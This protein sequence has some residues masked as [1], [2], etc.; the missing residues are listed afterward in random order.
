ELSA[1]PNVAL[2]DLLAGRQELA[3]CSFGETFRSHLDEEVVGGAKLLASVNSSTA[4]A[5]PLPVEQ[6]RTREFRLDP[7]ALQPVDRRCVRLPRRAILRDDRVA[8]RQNAHGPI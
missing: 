7:C 5:K 2:A 3:A 6:M 1:G 4:A 8:P